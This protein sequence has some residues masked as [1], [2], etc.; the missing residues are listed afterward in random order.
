MIEFTREEQ[1]A[2][3]EMYEMLTEQ[4]ERDMLEQLAAHDAGTY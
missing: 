3:M 2:M 4:R 1:E